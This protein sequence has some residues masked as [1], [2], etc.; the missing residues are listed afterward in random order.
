MLVASQG[1]VGRHGF[2]RQASSLYPAR[3]QHM[4]AAWQT[5]RVRRVATSAAA[6]GRGQ[7]GSALFGHDSCLASAAKE[8]LHPML[9]EQGYS[10]LQC[11]VALL[12]SPSTAIA[13][14][15]LC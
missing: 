5:V 7:A 9:S 10:L 12:W 8:A 1:M 2:S 3:A 11:G 4:P 14:F 6:P 15:A 13:V